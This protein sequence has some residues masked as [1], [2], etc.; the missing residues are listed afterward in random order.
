MEWSPDAVDA[1]NTALSAASVTVKTIAAR[2]P[3]AERLSAGRAAERAAGVRALVPVAPAAPSPSGGDAAAGAAEGA[4]Q[5]E[6]EGAGGSGDLVAAALTM[7]AISVAIR[8]KVGDRRLAQLDIHSVACALVLDVGGSSAPRVAR[9]ATLDVIGIQLSH[10]MRRQRAAAPGGAAARTIEHLVSNVG[11]GSSPGQ[12]GIDVAAVYHHARSARSEGGKASANAPTSIV[13]SSVCVLCRPAVWSK[14]A[15]YIQDNV[16]PT[17]A[18]GGAAL[19]RGDDAPGGAARQMAPRRALPREATPRN[20]QA[21]APVTQ[22]LGRSALEGVQLELRSDFLLLL[23]GATR[24]A[25]CGYY[26]Y[27]LCEFC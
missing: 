2:R 4:Q 19:V 21:Q 16:L 25:E 3:A 5:Q 23:P 10:C 13:I 24:G 12:Q 18:G 1:I 9:R 14:L 6:E 8:S 26:R 11:L 7:G 15:T 17:L 22:E 27:I 20:A